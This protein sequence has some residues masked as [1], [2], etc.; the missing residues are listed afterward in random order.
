MRTDPTGMLD[1]DYF[2]QDGK[3]LGNDGIDDDKVYIAKEGSYRANDK[4]GYNIANSGISEL[5][6]GKGNAV[7]INTFT[8]LASTLYAEGSSTWEEAAGIFSVLE[9]RAVADGTSIM[10]QASYDKGVYGAS[11]E[12]LAKYS[13]VNASTSLKENA[14]KGVIL[15]LTTST[16]Y[17]NGAYYWDGKDFLSGGGHRERYTPGYKFTNTSHDLWGQGDNKVSG[18]VGRG[19]WDYKYK[20]TGAAGNTTFSVLTYQYRIAQFIDV[21]GNPRISNWKENKPQ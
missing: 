12:G 21:K 3:Y 6:D 9:N 14:N 19:T 16:D 10:E 15:G 2:S 1:G 13:S 20:S 8:H 18:T 4:G 7:D 17:S 5:K 11:E